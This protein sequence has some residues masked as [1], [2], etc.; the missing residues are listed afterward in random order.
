MTIYNQSVIA[1]AEQ[2]AQ[3]TQTDFFNIAHQGAVTLSAVAG[4]GKSHFVTDTVKQCRMRDIRVAVAAPT[5]EQVFSLVRS[6][7]DNEPGRPIAYI[8]AADIELP[9][10]AMRPNV[11]IFSPAHGASGQAVVV[12]TIDKLAS[13][14]NPRNS[15]TLPLQAFDALIIDE[16]YQANAGR[17][18]AIADIAPRHLCVGD[19]GQ[20]QPFTTVEAGRQWRGLL[21]DPLQTAVSVLHAN[22]PT[23]PKHRFPIT[24]RLDGRGALVAK[25]FYPIDHEFGAAVADGVRKMKLGRATSVAVEDQVLDKG[26]DLAALY[27]WAYLELPAH[28]T[29]VAD[30]DTAQVIV[31][32]IG[33]LRARKCTLLCERNPKGIELLAGRIAIAV[34]HNDQ[35][36]M[37]R[38]L[39]DNAGMT[40]VVVDTANKLQ[41]L[42]FDFLVCWHPMAGL[43]EA[44]E[45]HLESGRMCVMCTRH[46]HA[47]VVV[48]RS[49]DRELIEGLAQTTPAWPGAGADD[50]EVLRGWEVHRR[51]FAALMPY[52]VHIP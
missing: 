26:L 51:V 38:G 48:G 25:C 16:S 41:G 31:D 15:K 5:N 30:P 33:R 43:D 29:L 9:E 47:C 4:A 42:E 46:R 6:I 19:S 35:K 24:R 10:W 7:A 3:S 20:I 13:A 37:V 8:P 49:G 23:T 14:R 22:H 17:Y 28:Q 2:V 45:F 39:L 36:A 18:Y 40:E 44:D 12:G 34:S 27:G 32:L 21:E 11:S 52:L 1:A 50:D